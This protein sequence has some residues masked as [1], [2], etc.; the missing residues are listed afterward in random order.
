MVLG[1]N[2]SCERLVQGVI[3]PLVTAEVDFDGPHHDLDEEKVNVNRNVMG[4]SD[5]DGS[6]RILSQLCSAEVSTHMDDSST[7]R[8]AQSEHLGFQCLAQ[9]YLG[10]A[11]K[12]SRQLYCYPKTFHN[13][14]P[15]PGLKSSVN[16]ASVTNFFCS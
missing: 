1:L 14:C 13:C 8:R 4:H 6:I 10:D 9:G 5:V 16:L 12:V 15:Q 7:Q 3:P 2:L 11:L